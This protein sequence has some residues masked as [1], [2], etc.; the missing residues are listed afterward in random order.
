MAKK[1]DKKQGRGST[2]NLKLAKKQWRG[3][4]Q[5]LKLAKKKQGRG[6]TRN[7][8]LAKEFNGERLPINWLNGRAVGKHARSLINECTKLVREK[9]NVPLKVKGWKE[10]PYEKKKML[11]DNIL[12][13]FEVEDREQEVWRQMG[14]SL[15]NYRDS[16]KRKWFQPYGNATEEAR[17]NVPPGIGKD[18]WNYLVDWW[19]SKDYKEMCRINKK[20]RGENDIVHTSG[21]K[22]FQQRNEEEK[23]KTGHEITRIQ[24][25]E[26]THVQSN[27]Q[28][29]NKETQDT[30]MALRSLTTQVN[31]G[32]LQMSEDQMFVEVF[33]PEHH[34]RVR[35]YGAGVTPT[36]LWDS[37]S[38]KIQKLEKRLQESEQKRLEDNAEANAKVGSLEE[39]VNQLK[40]SLEQRSDQMEQQANKMEQQARQMEEQA[41]RVEALM[42][43]MMSYM[44][45]QAF[46]KKKRT[47]REAQSN[48]NH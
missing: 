21:S 36:Q 22:S 44:T 19:T 23:E 4:T 27:G 33:G 28:A 10:V 47:P 18:D 41:S 31:E 25:F 16:L 32:S 15:K 34:G 35:G 46:S 40:S 14:N 45:P 42:A 8:K 3:P 30:L 9:H 2:R 20:N 29:V 13:Y 48:S 1:H 37:S 38:S 11:F 39:Q 12:E 26:I 17:A 43:Q 7:L 5:N 6:P 24:L